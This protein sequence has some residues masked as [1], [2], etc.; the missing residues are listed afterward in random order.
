MKFLLQMCRFGTIGVTAAI[1]N[2][3]VVVLLVEIF[4]WQPLIANIIGFIL[5][6]QVS[7]WGHRLWTFSHKQH[8]L[9]SLPKFILVAITGF[10]CNE[11]MFA[12]MLRYT[13][14]PYTISLIVAILV[15]AVVT[16]SCSKFWVFK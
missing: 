9:Q 1:V 6:F 14:W 3:L 8:D 5:A 15:A 11:G 7:Y 12:L 10:I 13:A 16:F 2:Y 4:N